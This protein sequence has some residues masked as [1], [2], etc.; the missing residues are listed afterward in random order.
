MCGIA[1]ILTARAETDL[2]SVLGRMTEALRHRGPD[3][4][5]SEEIALPGGYR[6]GLAHTRLSILD[7]SPAGHQPMEEPETGSWIVYNGET[8]NHAEIRQRLARKAFRS[9]GDTETVLQGWV[10]Q[11]ESILG[12]LRGM[13]AFAL[14]DGRRQQLWLVRDR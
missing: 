10:E 11:G 2:E 4:A 14:Y 9:T 3:D 8:Y 1:G 6:L 13:F 7:L 12:S 5:G